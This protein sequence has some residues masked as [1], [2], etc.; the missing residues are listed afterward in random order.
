MSSTLVNYIIDWILRTE[1]QDVPGVQVGST[2]SITNLA[3]AD[4]IALLGDSFE[5]VQEALEGVERY[6][7]AV[8]LR[9]FAAKTSRKSQSESTPLG[10]PSIVYIRPY[11][12]DGRSCAI[13]RAGSTRQ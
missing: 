8:G 12:Q 9:V 11:G 2:V 13:P 10:W 5:A 1:L 3:Y 6:A 7:A 4:D